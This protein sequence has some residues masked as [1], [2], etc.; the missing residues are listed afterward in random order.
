MA[1]AQMTQAQMTQVVKQ[2]MS[3]RQ[4]II[5]FSALALYITYHVLLVLSVYNRAKDKKKMSNI[6][7]IA[8]AIIFTLFA[9]TIHLFPGIFGILLIIMY[10]V[11]FLINK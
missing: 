2:G 3:T 7:G 9:F 10:V 8:F 11:L 5:A 4:K 1:Q 6:W